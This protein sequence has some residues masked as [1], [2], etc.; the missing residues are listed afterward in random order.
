[1]DFLK[2]YMAIGQ[3]YGMMFGFGT[4]FKGLS[5]IDNWFDWKAV[6][7]QELGLF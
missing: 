7:C 2:T 5:F 3:S 4:E 6:V 1:M